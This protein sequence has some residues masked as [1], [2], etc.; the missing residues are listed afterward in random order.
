MAETPTLTRGHV[1]LFFLVMTASIAAGLAIYSSA[2][3]ITEL[4][5]TATTGIVLPILLALV[6]SFLLEPLVRL[7]ERGPLN[8]TASI[9][10]VFFLVALLIY[11]A[12]RWLSPHWADMWFS[13]RTDLP[14]YL[15]RAIALL[16]EAQAKL[17]EVFPYVGGID[18][19]SR[20]RI[21]AER[22]FG[23]I[24]SHTTGSALRLGGLMV[25]VPL[26]TFFFL[27]DGQKIIRFS[28]GLAPNRYYEM[29]HDLAWLIS[30]QLS[31]FVRGRVLEAAIVGLVVGVGLSLTDIRY[32]PLLAIFAGV[33]NLVPY[34][35]PLV[36]MVPGILI[37][38]VDLGL[39]GQF[40][41]IVATYV[42]IAQVVVDN[43]ILIPIL[44][45][46]VSNLHPLWVIIAI[47]MGGKLYGVLGMIIGVP[48]ASIIK[49]IIIEIRYYRQTFA[50][51]LSD[52]EY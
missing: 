49:I 29:A 19:P 45:S 30:R 16:K 37:A 35:G 39:G 13:L 31:H 40:W 28:V 41:W 4:L 50:L 3:R 17:Q 47:I 9:F 12:I 25:L 1:L 20:G 6:L 15:G 42:L 22:L 18:L 46:H 44:I 23:E 43:F 14:R 27:R 36:G 21:L 34:L 48:V 11:L 24:L 52:L 7:F 2:S 51:P 38:L 32:A 10:L 33:T 8:R 5:H 26:F